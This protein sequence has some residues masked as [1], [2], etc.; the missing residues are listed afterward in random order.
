MY[1]MQP[2]FQGTWFGYF[3]VILT[4]M[5]PAFVLGMLFGGH[6]GKRGWV[7]TIASA[8]CSSAWPA[9]HGVQHLGSGHGQRYWLWPISGRL[10]RRFPTDPNKMVQV[11]KNIA[12]F[13]GQTALTS[14]S[15]NLGSRF[16]IDPTA[17]S[18]GCAG[19]PLPIARSSSRTPRT[20]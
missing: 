5:T 14:T 6:A 20:T 10:R 7:I 4:A 16:K 2:S 13:K 3:P 17:T 18:P 11:D 9:S 8:W 19:P 1:Y 12:A 15:Q